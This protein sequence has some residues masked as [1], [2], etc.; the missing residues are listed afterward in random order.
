MGLVDYGSD[1]DSDSEQPAVQPTAAVPTASSSKS[2]FLNLPP[3]RAS[4]SAAAATEQPAPAPPTKKQKDKGPRRII[5]DLPS[6]DSNS[7][8][9]AD[10]PASKKPR[11]ALGKGNGA[12]L[13]GLAAM[14][15]KPKNKAP[16]PKPAPTTATPGPA[17]TGP[18]RLDVLLGLN[19]EDGATEPKGSAGGVLLPPSLAA[20]AKRK[21]APSAPPAPAEPAAD[22]FGLGALR[23]WL[24][25]RRTETDAQKH[26]GSVTSAPSA[27]TSTASSRSG[28]SISSAPSLSAAPSV[29][30]SASTTAATPTAADPYPGFT[31]LPSGEWVAKDQQTYEMWMAWQAQQQQ[32]AAAA[33][34]GLDEKDVEKRGGLIEVDEAQRAK[35]AWA[36][37]PDMVP[38]KADGHKP[39]AA[40]KGI[41]SQLSGSAKRKH[42]LSSLLAAA[43]DNR[44]E[45]EERIAQARQNR[46]SGGNK[47]GF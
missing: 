46:K 37:R 33:P 20:K 29:G 9:D 18:S 1:S 31:Q 11:L 43:H 7:T 40:V 5:L 10:G 44:A 17:S 12:P 45:L 25:K 3:P 13:T 42:Q 2:S 16:P 24:R 34:E 28:L 23:L 30:S 39:A 32:Q 4:T 36:T 15:P 35:D 14:L 22:F 19:K 41:P 8:A 38:G 27:S 21:A 6:A 47:Y 26:A